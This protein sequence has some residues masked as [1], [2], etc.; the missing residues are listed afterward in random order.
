M[1]RFL[2]LIVTILV[3]GAS[4]EQAQSRAYS[5]ETPTRFS[6]PMGS[7]SWRWWAPPVYQGHRLRCIHQ[8]CKI[9]HAKKAHP[10]AQKRSPIK[11]AE[12][13]LPH[14]PGCPRIRFCGCGVALKVFGKPVRKLYLAANWLKFPKAKPAPGMVAARSGHVFLIVKTVAPGLVLAYDPNSGG[15]RTRLHL[16]S[17]AGFSVR[18]PRA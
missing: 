16:R 14:P 1:N 18:N 5:Y 6:H 13:L 2:L 9:A 7:N 17:L 8:G 4:S 11:I 10:K 12:R 15:H 3:F